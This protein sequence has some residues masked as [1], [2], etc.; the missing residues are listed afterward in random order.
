MPTLTQSPGLSSTES[1][2]SHEILILS[3]VFSGIFTESTESLPKI[4]DLAKSECVQ[5]GVKS[6][7]SIFGST[8]GP[9]ADSEY[10]VEPVG[11]E[12]MIPSA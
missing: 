12:I 1:S 7:L 4:S 3:D 6:I 11:V 2:P 9:P 5:I 10:A 8:T